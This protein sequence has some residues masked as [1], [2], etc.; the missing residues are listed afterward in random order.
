M[1]L[2]DLITRD[3]A[4][5]FPYIQMSQ[6]LRQGIKAKY[7]IPSYVEVGKFVEQI[8]RMLIQIEALYVVSILKSTII[9]Q[10]ERDIWIRRKLKE[11]GIPLDSPAL[12]YFIPKTFEKESF[13]LDLA[14]FNLRETKLSLCTSSLLLTRSS[15]LQL[16]SRLATIFKDTLSEVPLFLTTPD[17]ALLLAH[18]GDKFK[19]N[20][21]LEDLDQKI[22]QFPISNYRYFVAAQ[23]VVT[24]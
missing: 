14:T 19:K 16:Q 5:V 8:R 24:E 11:N 2:H 6:E 10:A 1:R 3:L 9:S 18:G 17:P 23:K 20:T 22:N 13:G 7:A 4:Q 12:T 21:T 15:F